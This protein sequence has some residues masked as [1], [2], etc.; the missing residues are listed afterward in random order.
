MLNLQP[1]DTVAA[2]LLS[3]LGGEVPKSAAP[4]P[5]APLP[6]KGTE[7]ELIG[8]WKATRGDAKFDLTLAKDGE[9]TWTYDSG[10]DKQTIKGVFIVDDGVLAMEPDSGGV[11]LADVSK[12][13]GGKFTFRQNGTA[14]EPLQF[15][16]Q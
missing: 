11:M 15:A 10:K 8:S 3:M 9:F 7:A 14:A 2:E 1:K 6:S 4:E 16:K 12:P 5:I 13:S